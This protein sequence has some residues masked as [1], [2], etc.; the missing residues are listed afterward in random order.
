M[1]DNIWWTRL[2][3][4]E[5]EKR[6]LSNLFHAELLLIWYALCSVIISIYLLESNEKLP[7]YLFV[8]FSVMTL[9]AS[10]YINTQ[11]YK[12]RAIKIKACYERLGVLYQKCSG[13][14]LINIE[15]NIRKEYLE[16]LDMCENHT[17]MD[18]YRAVVRTMYLNMTCKKSI[19]HAKKLK[20]ITIKP[21]WYMYIAFYFNSFK[22]FFFR[23]VLYFLPIII[24]FLSRWLEM[25]A[26]VD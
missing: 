6:L 9:A 22:I 24:W 19:E 20:K 7:Q 13:I 2:S 17:S 12:E 16:C 5:T 23:S 8:S 26:C 1:K 3:R 14:L 21:N 25:T 15:E 11:S 18:Y 10:L 4:I